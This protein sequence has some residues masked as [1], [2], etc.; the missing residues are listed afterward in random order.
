MNTPCQNT[1]R[2]I[3]R[4]HAN[5]YDSPSIFTTEKGGIGINV[6]GFVMVFEVWF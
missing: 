5:D 3:W 6:G 2:E 4:K 1:D